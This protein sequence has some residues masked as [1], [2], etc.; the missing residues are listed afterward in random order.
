MLSDEELLALWRSGE[1]D[2][3]EFKRSAKDLDKIRENICALAND[4][5][6]SQEVGV[7]FIGLEDEGSCTGLT[8]TRE[9][10]EKI[11]NLHNE[12]RILPPPSFDVQKRTLDGCPVLVVMVQPSRALPV[13]CDGRVFVRIGPSTRKASPEDEQRLVEKGQRIAS[14]PF[15][16]SPVYDA[17]LDDLDLDFFKSEYLRTAFGQELLMQD[18]RSITQQLAT[19]HLLGRNNVPT[20]TGLLVCGFQQRGFIPGAYVQ[21]V[22]F[23]GTQITDPIQANRDVDGKISEI[24]RRLDEILAANINV[25]LDIKS[26]L[27][28]QR[29]PDYP[30]V[31]LRQLIIN[32]LMHRTYQGTHAPTRFYWFEDRIEIL[33]PGGLFGIVAS[34]G[35]ESG[36]TDYR[37]PTLAS[38]MKNLGLVQRFGVEYSLLRKRWLK[39]AIR[40][41]N[42]P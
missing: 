22:R 42:L 34:S 8:I 21:F 39:M 14:R 24:A 28:E 18:Q 40:P 19:L 1:S 3:V 6:E 35:I 13:Y 32:A 9:M 38:A 17:T 37:N 12:G 15:D 27:H 4:L 25:S 10:V 20:V 36:A 16:L 2:R 5:P 11:S 23:A 30:I 31:A 26:K 29:L 7:I 33:S 41:Q